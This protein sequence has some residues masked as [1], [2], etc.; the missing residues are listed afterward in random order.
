MNPG[1]STSL[2]LACSPHRIAAFTAY[3][4]DDWP[5]EQRTQALAVLAPWVR[6]CLEHTGLTGQAAQ[7]I[8]AWADQ[9]HANQQPSAPNSATTSTVGSTRPPSPDRPCPPT[10]ADPPRH[11][12]R[13]Q[14]SRGAEGPRQANNEA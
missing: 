7:D 9:R 8:L 10:P 13:G 4:N 14:G 3:L 5:H 2:A 11:P 12:A 6:F 1:M